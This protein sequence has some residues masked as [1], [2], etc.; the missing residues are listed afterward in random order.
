MHYFAYKRSGS[1]NAFDAFYLEPY[2]SLRDKLEVVRK[3][4]T[5]ELKK[6]GY[7]RGMMINKGTDYFEFRKRIARRW[8]IPI[9]GSSRSAKTVQKSIN[10]ASSG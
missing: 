9:N 10:T 2:C 8:K 3:R 5:G 4:V 1:N 7:W 6:G